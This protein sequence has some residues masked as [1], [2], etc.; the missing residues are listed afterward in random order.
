MSVDS[1]NLNPFFTSV[2]FEDLHKSAFGNEVSW[3]FETS[4]RFRSQSSLPH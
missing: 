4:E 3:H 1:E 2:L